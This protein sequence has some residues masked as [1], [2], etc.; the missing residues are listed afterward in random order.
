MS[1][2]LKTGRLTLS[3]L[4]ESTRTHGNIQLRSELTSPVWG[5][6][7]CAHAKPVQV[8]SDLHH[9][10]VSKEGA[11]KEESR[12]MLLLEEMFG[13]L[14]DSLPLGFTEKRLNHIH[15]LTSGF[16][17]KAAGSTCYMK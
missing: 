17:G 16:L 9:C 15:G 5:N 3:V 10:L 2:L 6:Q 14:A 7:A 13:S 1:I 12:K 4:E 11:Q 8:S